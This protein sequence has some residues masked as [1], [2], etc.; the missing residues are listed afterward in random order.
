MHRNG[1]VSDRDLNENNL[2]RI[3][4]SRLHTFLQNEDGEQDLIPGMLVEKESAVCVRFDENEKV[5]YL[6]E[7]LSFT[8]NEMSE[9]LWC[10]F[11]FGNELV[12]SISK[13]GEGKGFVQPAES[14]SA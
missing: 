12:A 4:W 3:K 11:L 13:Y 1:I 10:L 2:L 8:V 7:L 6:N 5:F 9:L 14:T